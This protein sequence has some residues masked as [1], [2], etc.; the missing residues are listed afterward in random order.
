MEKYS[1][2]L[3]YFKIYEIKNLNVFDIN[4]NLFLFEIEKKNKYF[5]I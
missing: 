1:Y 2:L 5:K 4:L 3:Y